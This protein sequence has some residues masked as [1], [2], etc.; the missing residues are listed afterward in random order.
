MKHECQE[1]KSQ[2]LIDKAKIA[3]QQSKYESLE[4][5]FARS[6]ERFMGNDN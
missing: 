2:R 6:I 1:L 5:A 4:K 3:E